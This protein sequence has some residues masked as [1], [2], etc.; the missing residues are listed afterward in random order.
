MGIRATYS[1]PRDH[2]TTNHTTEAFVDDSTNFINRSPELEPLTETQLGHR[3][4]LQNEAWERIL[5]AS[6]GKLE[7]PKCLAY[8]V[9][10]DWNKG[11]PQQRPKSAMTTE[12]RVCDTETQ[13]QTIIDIKDPKDSH[14]TLGTHQNPAGIAT[15]QCNILSQKEKKGSSSSVIRN[16]RPTRFIW[17]II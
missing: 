14:K 15:Q 16:C 3:L 1:C 11:E 8:I 2:L 17:H 9:V 10:Y 6:G 13:Q 5:S 12:I 7:L 4:H